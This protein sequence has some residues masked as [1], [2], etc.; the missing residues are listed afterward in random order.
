MSTTI[1]T[2][3]LAAA[4]GAASWTA[5]EYG[6]HRFAMHELRGRGLASKQHLKH[7]AD[8]TYFTPTR[9]KALSAGVTTA[10]VLPAAW[11][12]AGPRTAVAFT[13]GL[14]GMY[15]EYEVAHRRL[16]THPPRHRYGRWM[17]KSHFHHHFGGPMRNFGVTANLWDR[18]LSTYDE[19][20]VITVP[21]RHAPVW[22]LDEHGDVRPEFAADYVVKGPHADGTGRTE[23]ERA[24]DREDAFAN[25][26]PVIDLREIDLREVER[27]SAANG[28]GGRWVE[29]GA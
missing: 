3:L 1:A 18:A 12:V 11:A 22:L 13:A 23:P 15:A 16:H 8:V 9:L 21:R 4:A 27:A 2:P 28:A 6:L 29:T 24:R 20:G 7:H 26:V 25:R 19:P 17:R 5:L 14:I 10:A